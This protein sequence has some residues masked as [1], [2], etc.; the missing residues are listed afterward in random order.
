M[1]ATTPVVAQTVEDPTPPAAEVDVGAGPTDESAS[2][3]EGNFSRSIPEGLKGNL[4]E[5]EVAGYQAQ[6]DAAE[7]P[8]ERNAIRQELQRLSQERH[9]ESVQEQKPAQNKGFFGNMANDFKDIIS[10]K[11]ASDAKARNSSGDSK[12]NASGSK[13]GR[14]KGGNSRGGRSGGSSGGGGNSGGGRGK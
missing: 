1:L 10:G 12:G 4:S 3:I 5:E 6:L 9:V 13:G 14:D 11:A 7:T 8:Q 2:E